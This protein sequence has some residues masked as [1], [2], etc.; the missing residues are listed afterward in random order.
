MKRVARIGENGDCDMNEQPTKG[1]RRMLQIDQ[2]C[3]VFQPPENL[4]E[5][6]VQ[7]YVKRMTRREKIE[8]ISVRYDGERYLLK[9]GFHR[10]EAARR[11][12]RRKISAEVTKGTLE[13]MEA[14]WQQHLKALKLSLAQTAARPKCWRGG[15]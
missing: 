13:E 9:D 5:T 10:L 1:M 4:F 6:D 3:L 2:I 8:P 15:G 7:K 12:K 14:E 11:L